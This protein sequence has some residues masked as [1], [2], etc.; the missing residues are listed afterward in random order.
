MD[1][2]KEKVME[3]W[4]ETKLQQRQQQ[5]QSNSSVGGGVEDDEIVSNN[6][7]SEMKQ[8]IRMSCHRLMERGS[9]LSRYLMAGTARTLR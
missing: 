4:K 2:T 9:V 3:G 5:Q 1:R 6:R 8:W 7:M